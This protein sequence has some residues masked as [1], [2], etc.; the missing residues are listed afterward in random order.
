[1]EEKEK[2]EGQHIE[3]TFAFKPKVGAIFLNVS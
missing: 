2:D 1:M 3:S